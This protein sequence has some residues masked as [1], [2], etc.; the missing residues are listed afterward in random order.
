ME[1]ID[2]SKPL[3]EDKEFA[4]DVRDSDLSQRTLR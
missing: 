1:L 4:S 3:I 2:H